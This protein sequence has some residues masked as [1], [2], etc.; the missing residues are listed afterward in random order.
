MPD[1]GGSRLSKITTNTVQLLP[2]G[3][4]QSARRPAKTSKS[5]QRVLDP[6]RPSFCPDGPAQN[7]L[8]R[9]LWTASSLWVSELLSPTLRRSPAA[10]AFDHGYTH[11][12]QA[13]PRD[14]LPTHLGH[15][16]NLPQGQR[17]GTMGGQVNLVAMTQLPPVPPL[18]QRSFF[19][20]PRPQN[21]RGFKMHQYL[22]LDIPEQHTCHMSH[23][24]KVRWQ[25]TVGTIPLLSV[26]FREG[27]K[28][29]VGFS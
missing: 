23:S 8:S 18:S 20:P 13:C 7:H 12:S 1:C 10:K 15:F 17:N 29:P 24:F 5:P 11:P 25:L 26:C 4:H 27:K 19:S 21:L 6:P 9:L 3:G 14:Y 2:G 22:W 28:K 16:S